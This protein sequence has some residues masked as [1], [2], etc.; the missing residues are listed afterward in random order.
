[1]RLLLLGCGIWGINI[2]R[3]LLRLGCEVHVVDPDPTARAAALDAGA[4]SADGR[5][6]DILGCDGV[7][8]ATPASVHCAGIESVRR[9]NVPVFVEKPMTTDLRDARRIAAMDGPPIFVM[10][11]WRYHA[12]VEQLARIA[13]NRELG[14]PQMLRSTRVNWTSPR[15]DVDPTW[16]LLPHDVSIVL[17][18]LGGIP[19]PVFAEAELL[20]GRPVGMVCV[21]E[22]DD[23]NI[24]VEVSTRSIH[25]RREISLR[26]EEGVAVLPNDRDGRIDVLRNDDT[27]SAAGRI[28]WETEP[29]ALYRELEVF[30]NYLNGGDSPKCSAETG[31]GIVETV[32]RLRVMAGIQ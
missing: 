31:A 5:L 18:I 22:H 6:P 19:R 10:H 25:K 8:V 26:C 21:L 14:R 20:A 13:R 17:E 28:S 3:D 11:T 1:M 30:V 15:I 27:P 12:G 29:G 23:V 32:V 4:G 2:L 16:T 7:V 24:V 9:Y